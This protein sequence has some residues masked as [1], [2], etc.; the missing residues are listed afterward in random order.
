MSEYIITAMF[1][2][3]IIGAIMGGVAVKKNWKIAD[4]F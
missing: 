4:F 2:I 3:A 1:F